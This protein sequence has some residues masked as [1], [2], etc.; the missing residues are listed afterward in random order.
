MRNWWLQVPPIYTL[1]CT[2]LNAWNSCVYEKAVIIVEA[3]LRGEKSE[4]KPVNESIVDVKNTDSSNEE[5]HYCD[6][7]TLI[8]TI[9]PCAT[10]ICQ[11]IQFIFVDLWED[12]NWSTVGRT[13][14]GYET[15][16]GS[17]E[18]EEICGTTELQEYETV[19]AGGVENQW[20]KSKLIWVSL[21]LSY[22]IYM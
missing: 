11:R 13:P 1:D 4:Q 2:D 19:R 21:I 18:E 6:A 22:K 14:E 10:S 15:S 12:I 8:F 17:K 3:A 9:F 20:R 16:K 7:S 5:C